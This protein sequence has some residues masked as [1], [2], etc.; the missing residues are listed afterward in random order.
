LC[1]SLKESLRNLNVSEFQNALPEDTFPRSQ[2][3]S[4]AEI[5]TEMEAVVYGMSDES[6]ALV[7]DRARS[8]RTKVVHDVAHFSPP[9]S[10][11]YKVKKFTNRKLTLQ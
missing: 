9:F 2:K 6:R 7:I 5:L 10:I 3:H 8:K 1:E 11:L 4:H